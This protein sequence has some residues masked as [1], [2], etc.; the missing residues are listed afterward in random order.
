LAEPLT[1]PL[2]EPLTEAP[3]PRADAPAEPAALRVRPERFEPALIMRAEAAPPGAPAPDAG[4]AAEPAAG[5]TS[6]PKG[7]S[8]LADPAVLQ[9]LAAMSPEQIE[10]LALLFAATSDSSAGLAWVQGQADAAANR[11]AVRG[12]PPLFGGLDE[13]GNRAAPEDVPFNTPVF[14]DGVPRPPGPR[15][16]APRPASPGFG[17]DQPR[18]EVENLLLRG[19]RAQEDAAGQV[20]I[21]REN[22][23]LTRIDVEPGLVLGPFGRVER[24][25]RAAGDLWVELE[26]GEQITGQTLPGLMPRP[27]PRPT[28]AVMRN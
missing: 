11:R 26:T 20:F 25:G 13:T 19:W 5:A 17:P 9:M 23:A 28:L 15:P 10:A 18:Q 4:A 14:L 7:A 6:G 22:D 1:A 21:I 2:T 27:L 16:L 3:A 12:V 24:V 8:P